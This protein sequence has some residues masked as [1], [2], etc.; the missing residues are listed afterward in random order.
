MILNSN[1]VLILLCGNSDLKNEFNRILL[2]KYQRDLV[3]PWAQRI[4]TKL[5][6]DNPE[7]APISNA[8]KIISK[9]YQNPI[10]LNLFIKCYNEGTLFFEYNYR[11]QHSAI[12][13]K[14]TKMVW[15]KVKQLV[16]QAAEEQT[17]FKVKTITGFKHIFTVSEDINLDF[18]SYDDA[19]RVYIALF[20]LKFNLIT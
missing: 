7:D 17:G 6:N 15:A 1:Q 12:N 10:L 18:K 4:R 9:L 11:S 14:I 13:N 19:V 5:L 3:Y 16:F 2:N 8:D 20:R